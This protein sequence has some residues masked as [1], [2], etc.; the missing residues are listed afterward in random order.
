MDIEYAHTPLADSVPLFFPFDRKRSDNY[1]LGV[2]SG[3]FSFDEALEFMRRYF[4]IES[5]PQRSFIDCGAN[6]G[7]YTLGVASLGVPVVAVEALPDNY[8]LLTAAL[9]K[10]KISHVRAYHA[11]LTDSA[12]II[13]FGGE[14]AW[15]SVS[16]VGFPQPGITL[17]RLLAITDVP[18]PSLLKIDV[19][20]HEHPVLLGAQRLLEETPDLD[21]VIEIFPGHQDSLS[22]LEDRGF[23][24]Y[25]LKLGGMIP[26]NSH[27]FQESLVADYF[28]TRRN[29]T[30]SHFADTPI[31][32]R[33]SELSIKL[34]SLEATDAAVGHRASIAQRMQ[35]APAELV[36]L[37]AIISLLDELKAD[38][39]EVVRTSMNWYA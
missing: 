18:K 8:L 6:V 23:R 5:P 1:S 34:V 17:D 36:A 2:G 3:R 30:R 37:P 15:G 9:E 21:V 20:G 27:D 31:I 14:S 28:C 11:G 39:D 35:N 4:R 25:M 22:F 7:I 12:K 10:N 32:E 38:S 33:S 29:I 19:E 26:T 13:N 24:C 16:D